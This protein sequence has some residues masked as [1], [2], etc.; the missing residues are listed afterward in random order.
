MNFA[1][2]IEKKIVVLVRLVNISCKYVVHGYNFF[3]LI[4]KPLV[5]NFLKFQPPPQNISSVKDII[6]C[7][8]HHSSCVLMKKITF[9]M[10]DKVSIMFIKI[11]LLFLNDF[12]YFIYCLKIYKAI[13]HSRYSIDDLQYYK[14]CYTANI[15]FITSKFGTKS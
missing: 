5:F 6:F 9:I 15:F 11:I 7:T 10:F 12:Y 8:R 3:L 4:F 14:F 13:P 2:Q 1:Q